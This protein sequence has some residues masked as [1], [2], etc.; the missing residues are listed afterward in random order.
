HAA[1]GEGGVRDQLLGRLAVLGRECYADACRRLYLL[2]ADNAGARYRLNQARTAGGKLF[3]LEVA[4]ED[5]GELIGVAA[6]HSIP[7]AHE[8]LQ[9]RSD[10]LQEIVGGGGAERVVDDL[11]L[12]DA[13]VL[14]RDAVA[15]FGRDR[16]GVA[17]ALQEAR[18]VCKAGELVAEGEVVG[19]R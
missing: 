13:D 6:R 1:V 16:H 10:D 4:D 12:V 11:E 9:A 8:G 3:R 15:R 18:A 5:E 17:D 19:A 14:D 2:P 7:V